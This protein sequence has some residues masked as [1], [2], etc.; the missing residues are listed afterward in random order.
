MS[1]AL[2]IYP[3]NFCEILMIRTIRISPVP[4]LASSINSVLSVSF[5]DLI[6]GVVVVVV[7]ALVVI[8]D[9]FEYDS[10]IVK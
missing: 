10:F 7:V 8:I 4:Q 9:E 1:P 3:E 6:T 5:F 2:C